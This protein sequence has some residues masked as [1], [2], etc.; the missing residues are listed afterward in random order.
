MPFT[1]FP[2]FPTQLIQWF[3]EQNYSFEERTLI[4]GQ[5]LELGAVVSQIEAFPTTGTADATNVGEATMTAVTADDDTI[6]G[7]YRLIC[8]VA[9]ATGTFTVQNPNGDYLAAATV[10]TPYT[11]AE[12]NFTLTDAGVDPAEGDVFNIV[13][14]AKL[15][16]IDFGSTT[17]TANAVGIIAPYPA[18]ASDGD[19]QCVMLAN[20]SIV[21]DTGLV[22][23]TGATEAQI[24]SATDQLKALGIKTAQA[25]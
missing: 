3:D 19:L 1:D 22:W 6:L 25:G 7:G 5:D 9:G 11:S 14:T 8:T 4:S 10:G 20:E 16:A 12:I 21:N 15:T 13:A 18:D 23:P 24:A 2:N 17:G